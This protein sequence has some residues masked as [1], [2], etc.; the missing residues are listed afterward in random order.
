[1]VPVPHALRGAAAALAAVRAHDVVLDCTDDVSTR[2]LL[3]DA[4]AASLTAAD[5][6]ALRGGDGVAASCTSSVI[7]EG[8][9]GGSCG[10]SG[11]SGGLC[12]IPL[13]SGA[14]VGGEGRLTVYC[15]DL[16]RRLEGGARGGA[17]PPAGTPASAAAS[18]SA[19]AAPRPFEASLEAARE[20]LAAGGAGQ[21]GAVG[22]L[23]LVS[24][25]SAAAAAAR[26]LG[27]AAATAAGVPCLRCV[28]PVPPSGEACQVTLP[29]LMYYLRIMSRNMALLPS[30]KV[31]RFSV[32][33]SCEAR[34]VTPRNIVESNMAGVPAVLSRP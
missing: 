22:T 6:D 16:C 17:A 33:P 9:G 18:A 2:Y 5:G 31:Q 29:L 34:Q 28:H 32:P 26:A 19:T 14:A 3:S 7:G 21:E 8:C 23:P 4:C 12:G 30:H 13:V 24:A 25:A 11:S 20:P 1:M 27:V 10:N 15:A